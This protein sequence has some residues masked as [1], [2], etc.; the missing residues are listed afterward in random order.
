MPIHNSDIARAF[1]EIADLLAVAD[2]N[3]FRVRAYRNAARSVGQC[4]AD[5]PGMV[6]RGE[7]LPR[8][9]GVGTDLAAKIVEISRT[10]QLALLTALRAAETPSAALLAVP[11]LGPSRV[12]TLA[13][14]LSIRTPAQLLAAAERGA[15]RD[16]PGFGP[17]LESR[18]LAVLARQRQR[19][20][21]FPR[22]QV[23]ALA[24]ALADYLRGAHGVSR[25]EIAG[26]FRRGCDTVGDLDIVATGRHD[27][28][29][30]FALT[31]FEQADEILSQGSHRASVLMKGGVQVDL[32]IV[33]PAAFG[34][35]WLY[36]TG[37]RGHCIALR[38]LAQRQGLKLNEYG[39]YRGTRRLAGA[40]ETDVYRGLGLPFIEP[41]LRE[42]RGEIAAA[43]RGAL[44]HLVRRRDLRGAVWMAPEGGGDIGA[45]AGIARRLG[46]QYIALCHSPARAGLAEFDPLAWQ[47]HRA[48]VD[49][50]GASGTVLLTGLEARIGSDGALDVPAGA[51]RQADLVVGA[52]GTGW[53]AE[54]ERW[55][56]AASR[57]LDRPAF[58]V[59]VLPTPQVGFEPALTL[60]RTILP[61]MA[62]GGVALALD[63][64]AGPFDMNER[65]ARLA[66]ACGVPLCMMSAEGNAC[67]EWERT[68]LQARRGWLEP[69]DVLN[70]WSIATLRHWLRRD[71]R[72]APVG[73]Q[74]DTSSGAAAAR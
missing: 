71:R 38:T 28:M 17:R 50:A 27:N 58:R 23:A 52:L 41:A 3:P 54:P 12:R 47:R 51:L 62:A 72:A 49:A 15:L 24:A 44:P 65:Q 13:R 16:L 66:S 5:L 10:G 60:L 73:P 53:E 34:A 45:Q 55:T 48:A 29:A 43:Q 40:T 7:P 2:A 30:A 14:E 42:D 1:E 31:V 21:R 68:I 19:D 39:L 70:H 37:S 36:F 74:V 8:L 56:R 33:P 59:L 69:H 9:A 32:C 18:L 6:G 4:A 67:D 46:L 26:S 11:G 35:A 57:A 25:V 61:K 22:A 63:E 20:R 64:R